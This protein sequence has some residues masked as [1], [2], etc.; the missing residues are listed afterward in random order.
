MISQDISW[1]L[2]Y[3]KE[4]KKIEMILASLNCNPVRETRP[5]NTVQDEI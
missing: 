3:C 5:V 2:I 1:I 4:A